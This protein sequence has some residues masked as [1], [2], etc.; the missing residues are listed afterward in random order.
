MSHEILY[1]KYFDPRSL[2]REIRNDINTYLVNE[3]ILQ[4]NGLFKSSC[5]NVCEQ[6]GHDDPYVARLI[7]KALTDMEQLFCKLLM[8]SRY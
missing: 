1:H 4:N 5:V 2:K 3:K 6:E 8:K 7:I